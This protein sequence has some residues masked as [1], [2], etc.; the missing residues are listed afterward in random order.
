MSQWLRLPAGVEFTAPV[1]IAGALTLAAVAAVLRE[2]YPAL[3]SAFAPNE[4]ITEGDPLNP[5]LE[6]SDELLATSQKRLE[7]RYLF[8]PP[9][10]PKPRPKP[11]PPKSPVVVEKDEPT[12]QPAPAKYEGGKPSGILGDIV[13]FGSD[14]RVRVGE[15]SGDLEI[16][17]VL[18]PL[19]IRVG[20]T[21]S[22]HERGEYTISLWDVTSSWDGPNPFPSTSGGGFKEVKPDAGADTA[23]GKSGGLA[24]GLAKPGKP[25]DPKSPDGTPIDPSQDPKSKPPGRRNPAPPAE[26]EPIPETQPA[27]P[28]DSPEPG[29]DPGSGPGQEPE[30]EPG[31]EPPPEGA[32]GGEPDSPSEEAIE[33]V[34]L[35]KLPPFRS[36]DDIKAMSKQVAQ[37]ALQKI[38][39]SLAL[40]NVDDHNRARLQHD[41]TLI[42]A[43]LQ[44]DT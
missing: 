34:P 16:L 9:K 25:G 12:I 5:Y 14:K 24:G 41:A 30:P 6:A 38:N 36:A 8:F 11:A 28:P 33:F 19:G 3:A 10:E 31:P 32:S 26:P 29:S 18:P 13:F 27:A 44:S 42:A 7:G 40:P 43:R 39:E 2:G 1:V 22:G 15:T 21:K 20:W 17:E 23:A 35:E 37:T 4:R